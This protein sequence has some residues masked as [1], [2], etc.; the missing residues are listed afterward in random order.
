[1]AESDGKKLINPLADALNL[2]IIGNI[3]ATIDKLNNFIV[4]IEKLLGFNKISE[5]EG[6]ALIDSAN[7]VI[8]Q[9][10]N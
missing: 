2:R 1:L 6:N 4:K 3:N 9:L 8:Y 5:S 10:M 7:A